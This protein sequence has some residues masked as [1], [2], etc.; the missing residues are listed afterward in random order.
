MS[1][2]F[3]CDFEKKKYDSL[4]S[5][6]YDTK[7]SFTPLSLQ[8][9]DDLVIFDSCSTINYIYLFLNFTDSLFYQLWKICDLP[10]K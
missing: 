1:W 3:I 5:E 10:L 6:A 8:A 4:F 9:L 7:L 2:D